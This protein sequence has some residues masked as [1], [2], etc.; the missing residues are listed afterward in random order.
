MKLNYLE[1]FN[2]LDETNILLQ[3]ICESLIDLN[4]GSGQID[5]DNSLRLKLSVEN[6]NDTINRI[7]KITDYRELH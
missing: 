2:K 6:L 5:C 3:E 1:I 4:M 7:N